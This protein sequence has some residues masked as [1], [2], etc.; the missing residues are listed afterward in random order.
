MHDKHN[1]S[2]LLKSSV[3][4]EKKKKRASYES[5]SQALP[6]GMEA[7]RQTAGSASVSAT[8]ALEECFSGAGALCM[9][10]HRHHV[11]ST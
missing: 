5:P 4:D 9:Q 1:F 6:T 2:V 10:R 8:R 7:E 11:Q 3:P